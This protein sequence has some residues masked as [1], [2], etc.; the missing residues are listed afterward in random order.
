MSVI[1][2]RLAAIGYRT[3]RRHREFWRV[4][5]IG[6]PCDERAKAVAPVGGRALSYWLALL[7]DRPGETHYRVSPVTETD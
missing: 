6:P 7:R 3:P 1:D 2:N 5:R 4:E